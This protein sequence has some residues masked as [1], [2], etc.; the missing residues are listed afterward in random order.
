MTGGPATR[1]VD[2]TSAFAE[3]LG[4]EPRLGEFLEILS[5]SVPSN[6]AAAEELPSPLFLKA[7]L[8][9]GRT[10]QDPAPS[11]V[12]RLNDAAFEEAA[13]ALA[14]LAEQ[15]AAATGQP[16]SAEQ[17]AEAVL[18]DLQTLSFADVSG[19]SVQSLTVEGPKRRARAKVGDLVAVP[20]G[21][22]TYRLAVVVAR[23]GFGTAL[24]LFEGEHRTLRPSI[25]DIG[26][27][28]Y[29]PVYTD[30]HLIADGTWPVVAHDES[31][32]SRFSAQPER[33]HWPDSAWPGIGPFGSGETPDGKL[34]NLSE[35]E[36][37][38][39]GLLDGTY[40]HPRLSED[41]QRQLAEGAL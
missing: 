40:Q 25:A 20:V 21:P 29:R 17:V 26:A 19:T 1:L 10:Y 16:A 7:K 32:L 28:R 27:A 24:G 38:E 4:S 37:R 33:Y 18:R 39:I 15:V 12:G 11:R 23:N 14:A 41:L 5:L 9:R 31:L 3:D 22:A 36:S 13:D 34:R 6:A 35:E 2:V 8:D 30:E